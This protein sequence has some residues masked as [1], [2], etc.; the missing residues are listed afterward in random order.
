MIESGIGHFFRQNQSPQRSVTK[1]MAGVERGLQS[2]KKGHRRQNHLVR[3]RSHMKEIT[4]STSICEILQACPSAR[5]IF[6]KHGLHGCG[7]ENG[8]AESLEFF[9]SV[10]E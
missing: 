8:P 7:G 9:A 5:R 1:V 3:E 10:H 6:D 2:W 4:A